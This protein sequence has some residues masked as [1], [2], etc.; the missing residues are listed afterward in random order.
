[1]AELGWV[2]L[3]PSVAGVPRS[4]WG[5]FTVEVSVLRLVSHRVPKPPIKAALAMMIACLT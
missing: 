1:M 4:W 3:D 2:G 5:V